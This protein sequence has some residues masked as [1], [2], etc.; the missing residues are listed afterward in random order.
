MRVLAIPN[1]N[2]TDKN[3]DFWSE[4]MRQS[5]PF[6]VEIFVFLRR[7]RRFATAGSC[8]KNCCDDNFFLRIE[9]AP[10]LLID[11]WI[12]VIISFRMNLKITFLVRWSI[13]FSVVA[14]SDLSLMDE[15]LSP[16]FGESRLI[17]CSWKKDEN[18][19]NKWNMHKKTPKKRRNFRNGR[20]YWFFSLKP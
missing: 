5:A 11:P 15:C 4:I 7:P 12:S 8:L 19:W 20:F 14:R 1:T 17:L 13:T 10:T 16:V 3:T 9:N 18:I 6:M 2:F